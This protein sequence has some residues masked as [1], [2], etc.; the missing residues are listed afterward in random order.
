MNRIGSKLSSILLVV[1]LIASLSI[2]AFA[3][4]T[5]TD[6]ANLTPAQQAAVQAATNAYNNAT[7]DA[8]RDAAHAAAEAVRNSAGYTSNGNG[9]Y[10]GGY[11]GGSFNNGSTNST[12]SGSTDY[13]NEAANT[14]KNGTYNTT[15]HTDTDEQKM[16]GL[17]AADTNTIAALTQM[18]NDA[19]SLGDTSAAAAY[20][21][22]AHTVAEGLRSVYGYS[23]GADGDYYIPAGSTGGGTAAAASYF[24][25]TATSGAGGSISPNYAVAVK[26]GDGQTFAITPSTGYKISSVLVDGTSVGAVSTYTFSNVTSAHTIS[27][28]FASAAT[29]S[30]GTITLGDGGSGTISSIAG[31]YQMK[32][33][34]GFTASAKVT[35]QYVSNITV[36]ASYKFISAGTTAL[37]N[38]GSTFQFP[39]NNSSATKARKVYVPVDTKDGTY[40]ITFTI[41]ALDPQATALTGSNV[42]LTA[43]ETVKLK[44][45]GS[46]YE[47]DFTG[48]S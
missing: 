32:S 44:I 48:N 6:S 43:T 17:S 30:G 37:E 25:I 36:T 14:E 31:G 24:T 34:Y 5:A 40:T 23:A 18:Y 29:L 42:Y 12:A 39:V 7:T 26:S 9:D 15:H 33:G 21:E 38:T 8:G 1:L 47:D 46:M 11:S 45:K 10:V 4:T 22:A 20:K 3:V 16:A 28:V 19:L 35:S 41:K 27:A 13:N 2:S